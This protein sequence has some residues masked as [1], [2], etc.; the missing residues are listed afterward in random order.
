MPNSLQ[1]L[2]DRLGGWPRI[3]LGLV[4]VG[5]LGVILAFGRWISA[6]EWVTLTTGVTEVSEA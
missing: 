2:V 4:A 5:A 3:G 6:P 1:E